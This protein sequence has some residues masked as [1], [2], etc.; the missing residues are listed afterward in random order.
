MLKINKIYWLTD[1]PDVAI[2][3]DW[4]NSVINKNGKKLAR[5]DIVFCND[6]FLLQMNRDYLQHD[7][8]TD[9]ITFD[10]S[11]QEGFVSG[12]IYISLDRILE[13]AL[14][15]N[16]SFENELHRVVIHGVLHLLGFNDSTLSERNEMRSMEDASLQIL[17][18]TN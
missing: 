18:I 4:I 10:Q 17:G 15:A 6:E 14:E 3:S 7:Y 13:N 16:T 2:S 12:D 11:E 1:V 8:Y 5:I 9:I